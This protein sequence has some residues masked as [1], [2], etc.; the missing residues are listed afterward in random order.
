MQGRQEQREHIVEA[1]RLALEANGLA[2]TS[3]SAGLAAFGGEGGRA[4]VIAELA[5]EDAHRASDPALRE[6]LERDI[7]RRAGLSE[8]KLVLAS[9]SSARAPETAASAPSTQKGKGERV[10]PRVGR[11]LG[12]GSGK[13]GV[14]KSTIAFNLA[15]AAAEA[16]LK[17]GLAD[18]DV[19]GPSAPTLAGLE[20][21]RLRAREDNRLEPLAAHGVLV[22]SMGFMAKPGVAVG[23][24]G[25]MAG[26]AAQQIVCDTAWPADLDLLV[27]DLPPGSSDIHLALAQSGLIDAALM[28]TTPQALARIDAERGAD[29]FAK[30]GAP[31]IGVVENM[32]YMPGPGGARL[33]PFGE[34]G[35][36]A[37]AKA[38]GAPLLAQFPL[39][40]ALAAASD[41]GRPLRAQPGALPE[42]LAALRVL[43]DRVMRALRDMAP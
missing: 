26:R 16:G 19:H 25:P 5:A 30:L 6:T 37:L 28:V 41:A 23:W 15:V 20:G 14:G 29:L 4:R 21:E 24:R 33:H 7:A 11:I 13:G 22:Q 8:V 17:T 9:P 18:V 42:T 12:V 1:A 38:C 2:A 32:S 35:G 34:G 40:P 43:T 3:K 10:R 31:I 39:D 36:E 27:V